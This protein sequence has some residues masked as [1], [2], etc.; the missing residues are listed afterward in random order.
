MNALSAHPSLRGRRILVTRAAAQAAAT[1]QEITRR[2]G[3]PVSFPCLAVECLADNI[4][5]AMPLMKTEGAEAAFSSTN[6]VR[7]V[8]ETMGRDFAGILQHM[9][10][11]AVGNRTATA[12]RRHD[13]RPA[14]IPEVHSQDGLIKAYAEHG[15]PRTLV[16]F[17]AKEGREALAAALRR[18]GVTVHTIACYR[19]ICPQD[20]ATPVINELKNGH[21]DAVLIGSA[22][23]AR[24]FKERIG[25]A[26][27]ANQA[28][29]AVISPQVATAARDLGLDV[30]IVAKEASF[31]SMLD[32]L[33]AHF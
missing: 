21:I 7:C 6:G 3:V 23:T 19:T 29:I 2:G 16:F 32:G 27:I 18:Q 25:D 10:V 1:A 5:K 8:A 9:R 30:Q 24:H 13:I 14:I 28:V 12:L 20:D 4:R 17:R 22:K 33:A 31:A 11:A 26:A 15:M